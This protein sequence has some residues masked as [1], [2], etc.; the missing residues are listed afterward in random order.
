MV[1][2]NNI[3][4]KRMH[5]TSKVNLTKCFCKKYR[6][7]R[8]ITRLYSITILVVIEIFY[9]VYIDISFWRYRPAVTN[10]APDA[11]SCHLVYE[12]SQ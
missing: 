3:P 10:A 5:L 11:L 6:R 4:Y 9:E 8:L 2:F 7:I 1:L 12:L